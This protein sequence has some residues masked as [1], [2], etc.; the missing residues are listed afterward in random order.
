MP[1]PEILIVDDDPSI[2]SIL[3]K[4]LTNRGYAVTD[5]FNG[6]DGIDAFSK[7]DF[8]LVLLDLMLPDMD[9]IEVAREMM[10]ENGKVPIILISAHGTIPKA[11]EATKQGVYDFFE[12]PFERERLLIT[13]RNALSL[14]QTQQDLDKQQDPA[15]PG[16]AN[17][18]RILEQPPRGADEQ[19]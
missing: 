7:T 5:V 4:I 13:I 1:K 17:D 9:G 8:D 19:P 18:R 2:C 16:A 10:S 11:V 14:G 6:R 12:K 15:E 3:R